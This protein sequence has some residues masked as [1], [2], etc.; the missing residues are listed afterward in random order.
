MN[1]NPD[2]RILEEC[3]W[4]RGERGD[5]WMVLDSARDARIYSMYLACH[6][7]KECL[8]SGPL[9]PAL[10]L[11]APYLLRLEYEE[12][13]T[14]RLLRK[15]WSQSWGVFIKCDHNLKALRKHLRQF[16]LV[17]DPQNQRLV[18]RYYDPRVLRVYLPTC[19][20]AEL[21]EFYGPIECFW[22][23]NEHA[24]SLVQFRFNKQ[25]LT[26]RT[27]TLPGVDVSRPDAAKTVIPIN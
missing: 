5:V 19:T 12:T 4:P 14:R 24:N 16:L 2:L 27:I 20:Q 6:L 13:H 15:G 17:R 26:T 1:N 3:L 8:Y 25:E 10:A 22:T 23:E 18:F 11:A 9:A 7:E 21:R